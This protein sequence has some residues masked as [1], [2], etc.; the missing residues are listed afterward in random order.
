MSRILILKTKL[1][2]EKSEAVSDTNRLKLLA[3]DGESRFSDT[4]QHGYVPK[5][6]KS[7]T[8]RLGYVP[9]IGISGTYIVRTYSPIY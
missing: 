6:A 5:N 4:R 2:R 3:L 1:K 9:K 8:R 7:G